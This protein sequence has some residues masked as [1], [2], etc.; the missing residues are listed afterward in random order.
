M[1]RCMFWGGLP[2]T[3]SIGSFQ[4]HQR[5]WATAVVQNGDE[6]YDIFL[7]LVLFLLLVKI[8]G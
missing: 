7:D 4:L 3:V 5:V 1:G 6:K 8:L 2:A